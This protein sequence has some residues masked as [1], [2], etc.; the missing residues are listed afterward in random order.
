MT[1]GSAEL[2]AAMQKSRL[3]IV[4]RNL[5]LV[6]LAY[7]LAALVTSPLQARALGPVGRGEL[8]AVTVVL[9]LVG[10]LG[11]LGLGAYAVRESA[12]GRAVR[13]LVGSVGP[14]LLALGILYAV[15]APVIADFVA[16]GRDAVAVLL[17]AGLLLSPL[18]IPS[19]LTMAIV[20]GQQRWG[21]Y[22]LQRLA[23]PAGTLIV[24]PTL[25]LL[26][27]L[28]VM[29]A[30]IT[31]VVLAVGGMVPSWVVLRDAGRPEYDPAV[32]TAARRYGRRV[33]VTA[34]ANTTN[35]RLDQL[36][37]TRMVPSAELGLYVVA[38][39]F[40]LLQSSFTNA[41]CSAL[42]PR[43][44]ADD[45]DVVARALRVVVTLTTALSA[46]LFVSAPF[47]LPLVFGHSFSGAVLMCQILVVAA[48]PF[49]IV[50]LMITT[51]NGLNEPGIAARGE[52]ISIVITVPLLVVF[53]GQ[54][55]GEAAALISVAAYTVTALYLLVNVR[56]LLGFGWRELLVPRRDDLAA[57][58]SLPGVG[59]VVDRLKRR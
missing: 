47:V 43:V 44:A 14:Q 54:Y 33:W 18:L 41:A 6:N 49:G 58:R 19:G 51:L 35:T 1:A 56:R 28:T 31:M 20:W 40:S 55:G 36:L 22:A 45:A 15:V 3:G 38:F 13:T 23:L 7:T 9:G 34:L 53:V 27:S 17:L 8:A 4:T 50:Q 46:L 10:A 11:D 32:A 2:G 5:T 24:F 57:L 39:N 25:Y 29:S 59:R 26:D 42:L 37:M 52:L 48:I 30:G 16:H 12:R 21:I